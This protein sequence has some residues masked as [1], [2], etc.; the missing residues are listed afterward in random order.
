MTRTDWEARALAAEAELA[1]LDRVIARWPALAGCASRTDAVVLA[2]CLEGDAREQ[3]SSWQR[4]AEDARALLHRQSAHVKRLWV[5]FA[6]ERIRLRREID[7]LR[8]VIPVQGGIG[9]VL[10]P[11][12]HAILSAAECHRQ[13]YPPKPEGPM[14]PGEAY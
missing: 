6:W 10:Q 7:R 4:E 2:C 12:D 11:D 9:R 8:E 5:K 1:H 13:R 3:A 14:T